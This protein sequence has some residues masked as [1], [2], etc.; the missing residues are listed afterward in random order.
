MASYMGYMLFVKRY[1][2][3]HSCL[4]RQIE[5]SGK[6]QQHIACASHQDLFDMRLVRMISQCFRLACTTW[7]ALHSNTYIKIHEIVGIKIRVVV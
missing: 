3:V 1:S 2:V 6:K 4:E 5:N 7:R